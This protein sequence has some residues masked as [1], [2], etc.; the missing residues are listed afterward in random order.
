MDED[1]V[2]PDGL[3]TE[4]TGAVM[5]AIDQ[6][7]AGAV[8]VTSPAPSG[9][10]HV[11]DAIVDHIGADRVEQ[12]ALRDHETLPGLPSE[13][14]VVLHDCQVLYERRIDGFE[15]LDAV[16]REIVRSDAVVVMGWNRYAWQYSSQVHAIG[17]AVR[18]TV[19]VPDLSREQVGVLLA[20][21]GALD[22][23]EILDDRDRSSRILD[24]EWRSVSAV[25]FEQQLPVPRV[26]LSMLR[27][28]SAEDEGAE[29]AV[30]RRVR[31]VSGGFPGVV[32]QAWQDA[33]Q[34]G[35]VTYGALEQAHIGPEID[36]LTARVLYAVL[37]NERIGIDHLERLLGSDG[38]R[39]VLYRLEDTGTVRSE[40]GAVM[41]EPRALPVVVDA[42]D[43][44][45]LLW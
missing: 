33:L 27:S 35:K 22:G 20:E 17:R 1:A 15:A 42:L 11:L 7:G 8:A 19:A 3:A 14:V 16:L 6:A 32:G 28:S 36:E 37:T 12:V 30:M 31:E 21:T 45:R 38:V 10:R 25:G 34:D 18:E 13:G 43:R 40:E 26:D 4:L 29:E 2:L 9:R 44:R 39:R 24:M 41:L 23:I 5:E